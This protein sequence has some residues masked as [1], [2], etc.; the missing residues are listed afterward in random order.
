MNTITRIKHNY[1]QKY[2]YLLEL[3][4]N[5]SNLSE[6]AETKRNSRIR[7]R[8]KDVVEAEITEKN[9]HRCRKGKKK[10]RQ[11]KSQGASTTTN[12]YSENLVMMP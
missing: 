6:I 8:Q 11:R 3:N 5:A 7:N 2:S 1:R 10:R 4:F 9:L 12:N